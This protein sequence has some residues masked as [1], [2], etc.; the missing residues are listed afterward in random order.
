M[1]LTLEQQ[2]YKD[3]CIKIA[4]TYNLTVKNFLL[5][6]FTNKQIKDYFVFCKKYP[7]YNYSQHKWDNKP[8]SPQ[9]YIWLILS[10]SNFTSLDDYTELNEVM[11][12]NR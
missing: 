8:S 3:E 9:V 10:L 1:K 4:N 7:Q 12:G 6:H 2:Q 11:K 5:K